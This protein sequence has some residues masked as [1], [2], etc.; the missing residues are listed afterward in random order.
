[1]AVHNQCVVDHAQSVHCLMAYESFFASYVVHPTLAFSNIGQLISGLI[2]LDNVWM[3]VCVVHANHKWGC[4]AGE[5]TG[6]LAACLTSALGC[7][8]YMQPAA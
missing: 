3:L 2:I 5:G 1:M 8:K 6:W 4:L 7:C